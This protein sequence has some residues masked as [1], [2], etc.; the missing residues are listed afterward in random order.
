MTNESGI[1]VDLFGG[2][3]RRGYLASVIAGAITLVVYWIAMA[4][5][6]EYSA[7]AILLVEPQAVNEQLVEAGA[8][9]VDLNERLNLMTAEILSR[10]RLSRIIE[11]LQLYVDESKTMT[12]Q[13]I[14]DE[15]RT[16]VSV[17]P[18]I[19]ELTRGMRRSGPP[20]I[21]TFQVFFT[22]TSAKTS[23]MAWPSRVR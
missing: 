19:P 23:A 7:S 18:V 13:E 17:R 6:N 14:V 1:Q 20:E 5:P 9:G 21:N 11:E 2:L 12:R 15:M 8:S 4:L 3:K 10:S 22:S 16:H